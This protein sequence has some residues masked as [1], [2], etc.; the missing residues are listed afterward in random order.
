M[1]STSACKPGDKLNNTN[2]LAIIPR[3]LIS[4]SLFN[5]TCNFSIN[6]MNLMANKSCI[7]CKNDREHKFREDVFPRNFQKNSTVDGVHLNESI[8]ISII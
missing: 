8:P 5:D 3:G 2:N 7:Y 6:E 1:S 4:W